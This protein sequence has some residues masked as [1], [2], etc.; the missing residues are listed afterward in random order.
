MDPSRTPSGGEAEWRV[1]DRIPVFPLPNV[2]FFPRMY[3]PLHIFEP[4]YREMVTDAVAGGQ[5]VGMALLKEGWEDDYYGNPPIFEM[6]CVGRLASVQ[7]LPDGRFNILLQGVSR[8]EICEQFYEK[9]YRQARVR[10]KP[11]E[12]PV[13]IDPAIRRALVR[14]LETYLSVGDEGAQWQ[15]FLRQ[16]ADDEVFVHSLATHLELTPLEKQFLM[17]ADTLSQRA[18]RLSDLLEFKLQE[19]SGVKGWR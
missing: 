10:L 7:P 19:R 14:L 17:E 3:L 1:P 2:V 6:G 8:F 16:Q 9:R 5:C 4:R 13:A 12:G 11:N 15:D 18:R